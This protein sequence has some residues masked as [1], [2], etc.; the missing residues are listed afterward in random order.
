MAN[1]GRVSHLPP[2][3]L[4]LGGARSGKSRHAERLVEAAGAGLYLATAEARDDEM[5]ERIRTHRDRRGTAWETVEEP[6]DIVDVLKERARADRPILVDCLTLWLSNL[7]EMDIDPAAD[8]KKLTDAFSGLAGPVV[9]VSNEVGLGVIPMGELTRAFVDHAGRMNQ[10]VAEAA[11]RVI[12][13]TAGLPMTL[14]DK[15]Q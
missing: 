7:L 2:V 1:D 4:V 15:S 14:K 10:A 6:I 5:S 11:D 9:L 8:V 13:V 3:T 12:L